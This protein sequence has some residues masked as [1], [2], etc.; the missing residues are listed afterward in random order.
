[1]CVNV[2]FLSHGSLTSYMLNLYAPSPGVIAHIIS[3]HI[4]PLNARLSDAFQQQGA[5]AHPGVSS[6]SPSRGLLEGVFGVTGRRGQPPRHRHGSRAGAKLMIPSNSEEILQRLGR[7]FLPQDMCSVCALRS[8]SRF[9]D[10][11]PASPR[12]AVSSVPSWHLTLIALVLFC[13][14][15]SYPHVVGVVLLVFHDC[16]LLLF[17]SWPWD[18]LPTVAISGVPTFSTNPPPTHSKGTAPSWTFRRRSPD[19]QRQRVTVP[20]LTIPPP[21]PFSCC[22][23]KLDRKHWSS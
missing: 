5:R 1:M 18:S 10:D 6:V 3:Y 23:T 11:F 12:K 7:T 22:R 2:F 19:S 13:R 17:G 21:L 14:V 4:I 16:L 20:V 9:S 8:A 15:L